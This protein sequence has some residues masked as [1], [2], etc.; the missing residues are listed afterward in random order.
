M[1]QILICLV[2]CVAV[3]GGL[4]LLADTSN[5]TDRDVP[6]KTTDSGRASLQESLTAKKPGALGIGLFGATLSWANTFNEL[7]IDV[8]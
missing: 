3:V 2:F 1:K 5:N 8:R 4:L 6:A 7:V